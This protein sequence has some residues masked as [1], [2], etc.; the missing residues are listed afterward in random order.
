MEVQV[1]SDV[2]VAV[3]TVLATAKVITAISK[4]SPAEVSSTSHGF[5]NGAYVLI[6]CK[7]L[8][9]ADYLVG[10]VANTASG[11]FELEG[12]DSTDWKGTFVSGTAELI[13]FG[14]EFATLQDVS[15]SGGESADVAVST[16]HNSQD[17]SIPGNFTPLVMSHG[18]IRDVADPGLIECRKASKVK[19]IRAVRYTFAEGNVM[20]FAGYPSTSLAPGGSAGGIVTTSLKFNVK[21]LLCDLEAA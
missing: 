21:G 4:D 6:K 1:W 18:S 16:I 10:R 20:V 3:Q 2:S 9:D 15:P 19:G 7:G 14:A 8:R 11:T 5:S 12:I 17:G 13:T